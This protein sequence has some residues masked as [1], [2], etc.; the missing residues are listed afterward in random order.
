MLTLYYL[1]EKLSDCGVKLIR[2]RNNYPGWAHVCQKFEKKSY[3]A[4][5]TLLR[6]LIECGSILYPYTLPK[7]LSYYIAET[8]PELNTLPKLYPIL[9]K[10]RNYTLW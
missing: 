4:E 2:R 1:G 8:I 3:N 9:I 6:F 10:C 5:N 7:T